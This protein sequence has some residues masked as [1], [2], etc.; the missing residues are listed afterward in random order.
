MTWWERGRQMKAIYSELEYSL[1]R[2]RPA[3][4]V[5]NRSKEEVVSSPV[6]SIKS[7][8]W[9]IYWNW[10][11]KIVVCFNKSRCGSHIHWVWL[12]VPQQT[13]FQII[14]SIRRV[15][16][17]KQPNQLF[18]FQKNCQSSSP[19]GRNSSRVLVKS[20]GKWRARG[21]KKFDVCHRNVRRPI[22]T[23]SPVFHWTI[24]FRRN[25]KWKIVFNSSPFSWEIVINLLL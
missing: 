21:R 10:K 25:K 22:V 20:W 24:L 8:Y 2:H 23:V 16:K 12:S 11:K 18:F 5:A 6:Q 14:N 15:N 4:V 1:D 19:A 9:V 7:G 17:K 13:F 3:S